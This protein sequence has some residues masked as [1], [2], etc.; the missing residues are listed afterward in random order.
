M[1][2]GIGVPI[3]GSQLQKSASKPAKA[4]ASSTP[5][6][7]GRQVFSS[8]CASCHGLD[9]RGG[10]HAPDIA[11]KPEVQALSDAELFRII[12]DGVQAKGMPGFELLG[13][14]KVSAVVGYLRTLQGKRG[15]LPLP[16]DAKNGQS[17]FFG[18]AGCSACHMV[19]GEG[20]FLG[21]DLTAY[22]QTHS[23]GEMRDAI[24]N[25]NTDL[26]PRTRTVVATTRDGHKFT[27]VARNEDN[28]SLQ[29]QT[30]D[31]SFHLFTKSELQNLEYQPQSLMPA[32]YGTK[33]GPTEL[34]DLVSYLMRTAASTKPA[35]ESATRR[36]RRDDE[37]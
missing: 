22:A 34:N 2:I 37:E 3:L 29:L 1:C 31:G 26:D 33:L 8:S 12:H 17:L 23:V 9:G 21:A 6:S 30:P 25:P 19:G 32:D 10:E 11:T 36:R 18:K 27:G 4:P 20:G 5:T 15:P 14:R 35:E 13:N 7:G 28:F 16:G 24:A